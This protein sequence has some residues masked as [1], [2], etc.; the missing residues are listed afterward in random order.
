MNCGQ[1]F[2]KRP[3]SCGCTSCG[4]EALGSQHEGLTRT[5]LEGVSI[6]YAFDSCLRIF[7]GIRMAI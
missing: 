3:G 6:Y 4:E 7:R 5:K 2:L 1:V